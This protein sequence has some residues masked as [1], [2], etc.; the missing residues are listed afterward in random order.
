MVREVLDF[1]QPIALMLVAILHFFP[2]EYKPAAVLATL[3]DALPPGSYVAA[4]HLTTEHDPAAASAG[5]GAMQGAGIAMQ[6]R[7]S[8]RVRFACLLRPRAGAA[9][10]GAR[11]GV[12][13]IGH[14]PAAH[15]SRGQ[16][17]RCRRAQTVRFW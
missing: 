7:D 2:D 16:L 12:A 8:R 13:A 15:A 4:S 10:R 14:R 9:G 11:V 5:Q 1:S 17:L 6:K 3:I